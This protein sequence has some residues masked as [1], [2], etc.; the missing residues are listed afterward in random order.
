MSKELLDVVGRPEHQELLVG[1]WLA[2]AIIA[3]E[4][5]E[6]GLIKRQSLLTTLSEAEEYCR[7]IDLRYRSISA[8][9]RALDVLGQAHPHRKPATSR[10][11]MK[12]NSSRAAS[13]G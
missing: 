5:I 3:D 6:N 8:V 13:A 12:P 9:R 2:I 1:T 7:G 4:L 10:S 11:A